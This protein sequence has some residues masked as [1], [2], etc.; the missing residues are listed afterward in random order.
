MAAKRVGAV[1]AATVGAV[2][3]AAVGVVEGVRWRL[4]AAVRN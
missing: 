4:M 3:M 1:V 2:V